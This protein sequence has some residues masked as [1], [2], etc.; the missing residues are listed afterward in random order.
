MANAYNEVKTAERWE[1][2]YWVAN[3]ISPHLKHPVRAETLMRPFLKPTTKA[4]RARD[5]EEFFAEFAK[6]R[7]EAGVG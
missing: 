7:K 6:Q 2:A 5:A 4:D 3:I 1:T